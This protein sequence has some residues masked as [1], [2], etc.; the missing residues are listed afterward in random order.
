[1]QFGQLSFMK[2]NQPVVGLPLD[3]IDKVGTQLTEKYYKNRQAASAFKKQ[4]LDLPDS[5]NE[6]NKKIIEQKSGEITKLFEPF[7][8]KWDDADEA[9]YDIADSI[10]ADPDIKALYKHNALYQQTE[11]QI[12]DSKAPEYYKQLRRAKNAMEYKGIKDD[13]GQ[14]LNYNGRGLSGD[15]DMIKYFKTYNDLLSGWK[16]DTTSH[17]LNPQSIGQDSLPEGYSEG[18]KAI[19]QKFGTIDIEKVDKREVEKYLM[20]IVAQDSHLKAE[21]AD[22]SELD[23][24]ATTGKTSADSQVVRDSLRN[25]AGSIPGYAEEIISGS[26]EFVNETK[27]MT[28]QQKDIYLSK[29]SKDPNKLNSYLENGLNFKMQQIDINGKVNP[30]IYDAIYKSIGESKFNMN[31]SNIADK[32]AYTKESLHQQIVTNPL[33]KEMLKRQMDVLNQ[34][35]IV[36]KAGDMDATN[37]AS[38]IDQKSLLEGQLSELDYKINAKDSKG[39]P[40]LNDEQLDDAKTQRDALDGKVKSNNFLLNKFKQD[41]GITEESVLNSNRSEILNAIDVQI[42]PGSPLGVRNSNGSFSKKALTIYS[43]NK[44]K[45]TYEI[46]QLFKKAGLSISA[47]TVKNIVDNQVKNVVQNALSI[48]G[49]DHVSMPVFRVGSM[50]SSAFTYEKTTD[51]YKN[52]F[53]RGAGDFTMVSVGKEH[54]KYLN[55][56]N[57]GLGIQYDK[58]VGKNIDPMDPNLTFEPALVSDGSGKQYFVITNQRNK[59]VMLARYDGNETAGTDFNDEVFTKSI[60]NAYSDENY[61]ATTDIESAKTIASFTGGNVSVKSIEGIGNVTGTKVRDAVRDLRFSSGNRY[62]DFNIK[63]GETEFKVESVRNKDDHRVHQNLINIATGRPAF[64]KYD[65]DGN[66][67]R[68]DI[69]SDSTNGILQYIGASDYSARSLQRGDIK[70]F[71]LIQSTFGLPTI[72][73]R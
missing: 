21:L 45:S 5:N 27:G 58:A 15:L 39:Q 3:V 13:K 48:K 70:T 42:D 14:A 50:G 49:I 36:T 73:T 59:E 67:V 52:L 12:E 24:F 19:Y 10:V 29:I 69:E 64:V 4:V 51:Y 38:Y 72:K 54:K 20:G 30:N 46:D 57:Q 8:E 56:P 63:I 32:A 1:M 40:L 34:H 66:E 2:G 28:A 62:Q 71:N 22:I 33:A 37:M 9:V 18:S 41:A 25:A 65:K 26:R 7:K 16:A 35:S 31:I 47:N 43:E 44:D 17:T 55:L 60:K 6:N 11:K 53:A 61:N 23:L 68:A